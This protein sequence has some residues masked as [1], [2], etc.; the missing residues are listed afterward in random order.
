[1]TLAARWTRS[2]RVLLL[3]VVVLAV[4]CTLPYALAP[5]YRYPEAAPFAGA[6][7]Y[8]PYAG[9]R[10]TWRKTSLHAHGLTCC[11]EAAV[12]RADQRIESY[13]RDSLRY[14]VALVS[15]HQRLSTL[16]GLPEYEHG[17]NVRKTHQ[18]VLGARH[19]DWFDFPLIQSTNDKQFVIDRLRSQGP[20]VML[21]HPEIR[22]GYSLDD[23]R[24]LTGYGLMEVMHE[25][26]SF[27][28]WWDAALSAGRLSWA[29]GSDDAHGLARPRKMGL[30]WTMIRAPSTSP[31]A[32]LAALRAGWTYAVGGVRGVNDVRLRSVELRGD[33]L[34]VRTEPGADAFT[35]IGQAG[36]V[37]AVVHDAAVAR[38][39]LRPQDT[40]IRT[41]VHTPHTSLY[42]NPVVRSAAGGP[43]LQLAAVPGPHT[44]WIFPVGFGLVAAAGA[45]WRRRPRWP[46]R[47]RWPAARRRGRRT[48]AGPAAAR[49]RPRIHA[50]LSTPGSSRRVS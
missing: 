48:G 11:T 35:F 25:G 26:S 18:I 29:T 49:P 43:P 24:R 31:D 27:E 39:V 9:M 47:T 5:T 41:V 10:G 34:V 3:T 23:L 30:S 16:P 14:D 17:I 36:R 44:G 46:R 37:R 42:L 19:V 38:Y 7:W 15:D 33:T 28:P 1:M 6:R 50:P 32:L 20:L 21:A 4:A 13:Y 45:G 2:L 22:D 8:N 40:Y 12:R